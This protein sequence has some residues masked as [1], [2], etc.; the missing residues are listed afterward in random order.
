VQSYV[1]EKGTSAE[2]NWQENLGRV[3]GSASSISRIS[4]VGVGHS[5]R[6]DDYVGSLIAKSLAKC[7]GNSAENGVYIFD[8]EENVE[9]VVRKLIRVAP[10]HVIFIDA[11]EMHAKP[12][13]ARFLSIEETSYPF[14]TTHGIPLKLLAHQFLTESEAWV[15]AIQPASFEFNDRPSTEVDE[16]ANA[17]IKFIASSLT[18][19]SC[20]CLRN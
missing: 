12:G 13:E 3:L 20:K 18:E 5:L 14:F 7:T 17:I 11:C 2:N 9:K 4:I 6:G 19:A 15:L 8:A 16:A 10:R 1:R